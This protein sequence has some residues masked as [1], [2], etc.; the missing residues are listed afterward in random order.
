VI[1]LRRGDAGYEEARRNAAWRANLPDRFPAAIAVPE[2]DDDVVAAVRRASAEGWKIGVKSG[3]HSWTSPHLRDGALLIDTARMTDIAVNP[4][5]RTSWVRPAVRTRALNRALA[6]HGLM[7]PGGHHGNVAVGG[8]T[9]SGGFGWN[10]RAVGNA[11]AN[12]LAIEVVTAS[13]ELI[14]ADET[15][16]TEF[17]WAARGAGPG[18]FGA[19][20]RMQLRLHPVATAMRQSV[21]VYPAAALEEV[22]GW[23]REITPRVPSFVELILMGMAHDEAN[24]AAPLRI[25]VSALA[26][27]ESEAQARQA[28]AVLDTCPAIGRAMRLREV[29]PATIEARLAQSDGIYPGG[30]R[31][32]CDNMYTD[33]AAGDL[34]PHMRALYDSLPAPLSH[35][36]WMAWGPKRP[37]PDM[38]MSVQGE[39]YLACY[40]VWDDPA[41]DARMARWPVD[42]MR[43]LASLSCGSQMNDENMIGRPS[44]YLSASARTRLETLRARHDPHRRFVSF[45]E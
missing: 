26:H 4:A 38:A 9:M 11:C 32:A 10:S 8:F 42:R 21:H 34:V 30:L 22:L 12:L 29:E 28:L 15:Q 5:A 7:F 17:L 24:R 35:V 16:N 43:A 6:A 20:T 45:L 3:G 41:D 31:Y 19:V 18:F 39:T 25:V 36:I 1:L 27:A 2:N 44:T 23:T 13:G 40:A 33:A 14:R 37:L